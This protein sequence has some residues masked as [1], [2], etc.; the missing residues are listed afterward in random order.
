MNRFADGMA[1]LVRHFQTRASVSIIYHRV[2]S[3]IETDAIPLTVWAGTTLFKILDRD[4]QRM[5]WSH[6]DYLIPKA[7]LKVGLVLFEPKKGDWIE[8]A[9]PLPIGLLKFELSAPEN[10]PVWRDS[11]TQKTVY[12]VHTKRVVT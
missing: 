4:V 9:F 12:R 5:E 6:R 11:D 8:E 10:E 2:E 1:R 7:D 3:G